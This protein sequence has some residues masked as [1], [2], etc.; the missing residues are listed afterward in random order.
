MAGT[1]TLNERALRLADHMASTAA[2]LRIAVQQTPTPIDLNLPR[3]TGRLRN[4]RPVQDE[5]SQFRT[6]AGVRSA[7]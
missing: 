1:P 7:G 6:A 5:P 3:P 4:V 2:A